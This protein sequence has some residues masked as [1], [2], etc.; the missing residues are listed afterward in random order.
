MHDF[1]SANNFGGNK[2]PLFCRG[3]GNYS[4]AEASMPPNTSPAA[5]FASIATPS[6]AFLPCT[7]LKAPMI[8]GEIK[9]LFSAGEEV[10]IPQQRLQ[11]LL[12]N[13]R[14]QNWPLLQHPPLPVFHAR[15]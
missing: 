15:C 12:I 2:T 8:L 7:I 13:F 10:I 6:I 4:P 1:E 9:H 14:P 3:R 5:D 11:C